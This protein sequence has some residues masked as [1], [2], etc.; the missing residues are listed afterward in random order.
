MSVS[1][2]LR[3]ASKL[4]FLFFFLFRKNRSRF[5]PSQHYR[6]VQDTVK[7]AYL[8]V[9]LAKHHGITDYIF[10][11]DSSQR[12]EELFGILRSMRGGDMN[13][14]FLG[15]SQRVG[16]AC[17]LAQIFANHPE[18]NNPARKIHSTKDRKNVRS[19]KGDTKIATVNLE[20][21]WMNGLTA[22]I[23]CLKESNVFTDDELN[24]NLILQNEP[25]VDL[26]RPH[27]KTIGVLA[28]DQAMIDLE[29][30]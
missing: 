18:W 30:E 7:G 4:G 27:R 21:C 17:S 26:L 25:G 5:F 11:F 6:N 15:L 14:D 8:S 1:E 24:Y 13:F 3:T 9:A 16:T 22:A 12:L 28:G 2:F 20:A 19:W 29:D 23:S 10:F